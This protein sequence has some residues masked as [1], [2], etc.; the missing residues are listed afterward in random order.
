MTD[1]NEP[2]RRRR[3]GPKLWAR[4]KKAYTQENLTARECHERF[5][6]SVSALRDR[7]RREGWTKTQIWAA[8]AE[9]LAAGEDPDASVA[10]P[11]GAETTAASTARLPLEPDDLVTMVDVALRRALDA[12]SSGRPAEAQATIKAA[13]AVGEFAEFVAE[14]KGRPIKRPPGL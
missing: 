4:V 13:N 9:A 14:M 5:G 8:E 1:V 12:L 6:V 10:A 2:E 3:C 11:A 7:A